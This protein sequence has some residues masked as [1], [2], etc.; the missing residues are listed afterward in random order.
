[1]RNEKNEIIFEKKKAK[2]KKPKLI[3]DEYFD[4]DALRKIESPHDVDRRNSK[5]KN[6]ISL[7]NRMKSNKI[8]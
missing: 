1:M 6:F 3:L 4:C 8:H 7:S 2:N 5:P